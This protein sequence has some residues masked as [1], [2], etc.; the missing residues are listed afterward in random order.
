[1]RPPRQMTSSDGRHT[2]VNGSPVSSSLRMRR[3]WF[4]NLRSRGKDPVASTRG[5][6]LGPP[7]PLNYERHLAWTSSVILPALVVICK[8]FNINFFPGRQQHLRR[9]FVPTFSCSTHFH[10]ARHFENIRSPFLSIAHGALQQIYPPWYRYRVFAY[11]YMHFGV[12]EF[13]YIAYARKDTISPNQ[14]NK[15]TFSRAWFNFHVYVTPFAEP[16][17]VLLPWATL[18]ISLLT[19]EHL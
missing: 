10:L 6:C 18:V 9:N 5:H 7:H 11:R 13:D 8:T 17:S 15:I 3:S 16:R 19:P 2:W 4:P 1:V 14:P 12:R